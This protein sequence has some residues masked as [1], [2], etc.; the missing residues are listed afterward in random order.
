[1][2]DPNAAEP[3]PIPLFRR[4]ER[5]DWMFDGSFTSG[6]MFWLLAGFGDVQVVDGAGDECPGG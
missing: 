3:S 5:R 2:S 4:N 6:F 1:M